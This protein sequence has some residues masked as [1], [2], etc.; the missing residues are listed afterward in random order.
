M[1]ANK[2][3]INQYMDNPYLAY[4]DWYN[5]LNKI[6]MDNEEFVSVLPS[7]ESI[8]KLFSAWI[9]DYHC[10]MVNACIKIKELKKLFPDGKSMIIAALADYLGQNL[11]VQNINIISVSSILII[12]GFLDTYC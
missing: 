12:D 3:L 5:S 8:E 2:E 6:N 9:N 10:I 4:K 7:I 1:D 11:S